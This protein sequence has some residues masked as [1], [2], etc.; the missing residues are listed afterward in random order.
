MLILAVETSTP[1]GSVALVEAPL[2]E[3]KLGAEE[4]VLG[5][6]TLNLPGTHSEKL[7][8][9]IANLLREASLSVGDIGGIALAL[10]PGSF[11]GLRIGV[12]TVKGLAYA[13]Q[14]PVV[15]VPTLDAL[16]QNLCY[17]P[18][19]V[20]PVLDARKKEV[21]AA[22]FRGDGGGRLE[23]ISADWVI[24]PEDLCSR[25]QEKVIFLGNGIEVYGETFR[26][27]LGPRVFFAPPEFS[28]PRAVHVA[29]LS[30]PQFKNGHTLN[31]FSF[32]PVYLRRSEAETHYQARKENT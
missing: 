19:L 28:L 27:K 31:L 14:V 8:P 5:E 17:A 21:Y 16:A 3:K 32:T 18:S 9:A 4:K 15:G 26:K 1:T 24:A 22:L 12:S 29:R 11:T 2:D 6:H 7:M 10:G 13:L 25:I 20:C 23:K 30:L